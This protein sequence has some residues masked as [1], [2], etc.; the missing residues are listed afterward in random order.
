[1]AK[2]LG[3]GTSRGAT[4]KSVATFAFAT[5]FQGK[6]VVTRRPQLAPLSGGPNLIR[7]VPN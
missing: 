6:N 3:E 7:D 4:E 5:C 1:L 2:Y